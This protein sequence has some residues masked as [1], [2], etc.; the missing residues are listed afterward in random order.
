EMANADGAA[1]AARM[2][3]ASYAAELKAIYGPDLF[4]EPERAFS[5]GVTALEAFEQDWRTFYPYTSKYDAYLAGKATLTPQEARGLA[6]LN[7]ETKA[8]CASC[9]ISEPAANGKA[10]QF[11]DFGLIA[12]GLPRNPEIPAN[13]DPNYY[14]LGLCGPQRAD[15]ADRSEYCGLFR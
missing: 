2:S 6:L 11:S 8:N 13:A 14:D 9:H 7:D 3:Q 10:P 1:V 4:S 15:L 5:V 12:L